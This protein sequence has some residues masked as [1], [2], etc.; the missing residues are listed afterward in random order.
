MRKHD[1]FKETKKR[2]VQVCNE[3]P[4]TMS[5]NIS[6]KYDRYLDLYGIFFCLLDDFE[7]F[8]RVYHH[9][10]EPLSTHIPREHVGQSKGNG[11]KKSKNEF[12]QF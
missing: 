7:I 3:V 6:D 11:N 9:K 1:I 4:Y 8:P 2:K 12:F 5:I 10:K